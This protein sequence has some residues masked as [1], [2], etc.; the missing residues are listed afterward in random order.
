MAS[1]SKVAY[2]VVISD[3]AQEFIF[4]LDE[5]SRRICTS[6]LQKLNQPYPGRGV[7]DKERLVIEG[8]EMY[9]LHIGRSYTAFY[10]IIEE[11]KLV[12]VL[13]VMSIETAHK[14]YG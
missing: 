6:N 10:L 4:N 5:K 2:S 1:A 7:G 3:D 14:R 11:A 13:E 8:E 12:R 9:R